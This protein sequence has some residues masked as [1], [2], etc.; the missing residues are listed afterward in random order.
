MLAL[1]SNLGDRLNALRDAV[2]AVTPFFSV[3]AASAVYET[4]AAYVTDQPAF[5]N[6]ALIGT[7]S[8]P[9]LELLYALKRCEIELGRQASFRFGPRLIDLDLIFYGQHVMASN[10]LT[11]PHP[12]LAE[13]EF[14]LRPLADIAGG[15]KHPL[16]SLTIDAML[17]A[18]PSYTAKRVEERLL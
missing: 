10:E 16:T 1:G 18:L 6:A 13:R 15:W 14:V 8:L 7:T 17:A 2:A 3:Q 5:L 11:L 12:R 4:P 9:P